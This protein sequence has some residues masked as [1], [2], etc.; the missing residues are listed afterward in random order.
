MQPD[1][2]PE[3]AERWQAHRPALLDLAFRMLGDIGEAEDVVQEAFIRLAA[4]NGEPIRDD[5]GWLIVVTSRLCLDRA[6]S[7]RA[8]RESPFDFVGRD[9]SS[10]VLGR[11]S[12][13]PADRVT[14]DDS[15]RLALLVL[16][17]RMTPAERV[18]F[19]LHEVFQMPFAEIG[20]TV[21]R[22]AAA[23]RQLLRRARRRLDSAG[24]TR[25]ASA[26]R[27][28]HRELTQR[29]MQAC[30]NGDLTGLLALLDPD[31]SGSVELAADGSRQRVVHG[32]ANVARNTLGYWGQRATLVSLP[33]AP[34]P[35]LLGF[36]HRRPAAL[37]SL[38]VGDGT[39][40]VSKIHVI[41]IRA[42]A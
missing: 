3:L 36:V 31:V 18:V 23:C 19:V 32:A 11:S 4:A 38:T 21:G 20:E 30:S 9:P 10:V 22:S 34:Q 37:I 2:S 35:L 17:D 26:G 33:F 42:A 8:R 28:D 24:A 15:V 5:R 7:A 6:R 41:P 14:L 13:D 40:L 39:E 29:F 25:A 27:T 1:L 12:V 16:I